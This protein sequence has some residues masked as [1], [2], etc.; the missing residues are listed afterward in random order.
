MQATTFAT[1][2]AAAGSVG[3]SGGPVPAAF[4]S[5]PP[6]AATTSAYPLN[7]FTQQTASDPFAQQLPGWAAAN[8]EIMQLTDL[9]QQQ[10]AE[11]NAAHSLLLE[12]QERLAALLAPYLSED[13]KVLA[14]PDENVML[15]KQG[16]DLRLIE[17]EEDCRRIQQTE[18]RL[19]RKI[20]DCT[21][22]Y[23]ANLFE[24][25]EYAESRLLEQVRDQQRIIQ[26]QQRE[27]DELRFQRDLYADETKRLRHICRYGNWT[28]DGYG[29][30]EGEPLP[31]P[32]TLHKISSFV[33][34]VHSGWMREIRHEKRR[35]D[36]GGGY[37][38]TDDNNAPS[39]PAEASGSDRERH[40][41]APPLKVTPPEG[42]GKEK[43]VSPVA[44]KAG[45]EREKEKKAKPKLNL[46]AAAAKAGTSSF[47]SMFSFGSQ[48]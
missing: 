38:D 35:A 43:V 46:K 16:L 27:L 12:D 13:G 41:R 47:A 8:H 15:L 22:N 34:C 39:L 21:V 2:A 23:E 6:A 30:G 37:F 29:A 14:P 28:L 9:Y 33:T 24:A 32:R 11:L 40:P 36:G 31:S 5:P 4:I 42:A 7:P 17:F 44:A 19:Q 18:R 25:Q 26:L 3:S 45:R 10:L 20:E 1:P 48:A